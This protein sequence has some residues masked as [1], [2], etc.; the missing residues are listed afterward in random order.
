M[1]RELWRVLHWVRDNMETVN[2]YPRLFRT[3]LEYI[4]YL[5]NN[6]RNTGALH[7]MIGKIARQDTPPAAPGQDQHNHLNEFHVYL[8]R[9]ADAIETDRNG[10]WGNT[11]T[12][13][14][15]KDY[16]HRKIHFEARMEAEWKTV[17]D[18]IDQRE[19][20]LYQTWNIL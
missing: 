20:Q 5:S 13:E 14:F 6:Q 4:Q 12:P 7:N 9:L 1:T 10:G 15:T 8:C 16:Q 18:L 2:S 17:Q 19:L 11:T 3:T